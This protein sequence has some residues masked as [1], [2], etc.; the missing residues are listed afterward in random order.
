M[1]RA[2]MANLIRQLRVNGAAGAT[3]ENVNGVLYWTDDQLEDILDRYSSDVND[4]QLVTYSRMESGVTVWKQYYLPASVPLDLEGSAT[5]GE[6]TVVDTLGNVISASDYTFDL[7][8][9]RID[10]TVSQAGRSYFLR[11]RA[12]D[13]NRATSELWSKKAGLRAELIDW[14]AGTYN[15]KEDQVYQHALHEAARWAGKSGFNRVRLNRDDYAY[16]I[17]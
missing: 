17:E 1:A 13:L 9:R 6:F 14:K 15:L 8:R 4:I 5:V 2:G 11:A 10:F 7:S 3:D 12:F 16:S